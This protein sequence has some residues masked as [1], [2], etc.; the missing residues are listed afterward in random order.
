L[1]SE[2]LYQQLTETG[3]DTPTDKYWTMVGNRYGRVRGRIEGAEGFGNPRGTPTVSTN[4]NPWE[5]PESKLPTKENTRAPRTY[6]VEGLSD[7]GLPNQ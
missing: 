1:P 4:L 7:K 2:R 3:A 5:L 6:I